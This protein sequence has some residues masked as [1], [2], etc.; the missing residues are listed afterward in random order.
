LRRILNRS[1]LQKINNQ[2]NEGWGTINETIRPMST[3]KAVDPK[4]EM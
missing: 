1:K 4:L 3:A 2:R